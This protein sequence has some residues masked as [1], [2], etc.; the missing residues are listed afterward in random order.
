MT[1][2]WIAVL[3]YVGIVALL[4]WEERRREKDVADRSA[5]DVQ[6]FERR[7]ASEEYARSVKGGA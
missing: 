1:V 6:E 4:V 7:I 5:F 2:L 3:V